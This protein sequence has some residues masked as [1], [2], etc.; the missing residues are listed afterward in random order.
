MRIRRPLCL[1]AALF[2]ILLFLWQ[3]LPF[4]AQPPDL[5][6]NDSGIILQGVLQKR[7]MKNG[8]LIWHLS[9]AAYAHNGGSPTASEVGSDQFQNLFD[10]N[11]RKAKV[12]CYMKEEYRAVIGSRVRICGRAALFSHAENEGQFDEADYY[13]KKGYGF[14]V[15]QGELLKTQ[16]QKAGPLEKMA[17]LR[18]STD[19]FYRQSIGETRGSVLSAM[20]LGERG[21]MDTEIRDLY[22]QNGIAHILAISGLHISLI[23]LSFYKL[24]RRTGVP[25]CVAAL[26]GGCLLLFYGFLVGGGSSVVRASVMLMMQIVADLTERTYDMLTAMAFSGLLLL[27]F[28]REYLTD[29]GFLLSFLAVF[30]IALFAPM[31]GKSALAAT[32]GVSLATMPVLLWYYFEF[33]LYSLIL[34]LLLVPLL[35]VI[36]ISGIAGGI[37][38][39]VFLL[40]P[41][42]LVLRLYEFVCR[43]FLK[44]PFHTLLTGRPRVWQVVIYYVLLCAVRLAYGYRRRKKTDA[45]ENESGKKGRALQC[46]CLAVLIVALCLLFMNDRKADAVDMLSVGQGDCLILRDRKGT[47]VIYDAGSSDVKEAGKYRLIPYLKYNGIRRIEAVYLSH[48]HKDHY[49]AIVELYEQCAEGT[50]RVG[51]LFVGAGAVDMQEYKQVFAAVRRAGRQIRIIYPGS[52]Q[53]FGSWDFTVLHPGEGYAPEDVNDIS[54]VLYGTSKGFSILLTGDATSM[55]D[56]QLLKALRQAGISRVDCLKVAHHGS[57]MSNSKQLLTFLRPSA[58]IISCGRDNSYGHPHKEVLERLD[59]I[60]T[61]YYITARSGQIRTIIGQKGYRVEIPLKTE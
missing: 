42:D 12:I 43:L 24:L 32:L 48:P 10:G 29:A 13:Y 26:A 5:P 39:L 3:L 45:S 22:R 1:Y 8:H 51:D 47:A 37:F 59:G 14:K 18:E 36:L 54:L 34:N 15:F 23:G 28:R 35:S 49:S 44:L 11:G 4:Q 55:T 21:G 33:P 56:D 53:S 19:L 31:F 20:V 57:A 60:K 27:C 2:A 30:G 46:T 9:D 25:L 50:I 41:A 58:A 52:R 16:K 38:R 40:K 61:K 7:E 6:E 17:R